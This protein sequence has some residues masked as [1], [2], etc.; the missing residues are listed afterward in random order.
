MRDDN[1]T[2]ASGIDRLCDAVAAI[3]QDLD[4]MRTVADPLRSHP[5]TPLEVQA[6]LEQLHLDSV[7]SA[8]RVA[9]LAATADGSSEVGDIDPAVE[10]EVERAATQQ[11]RRT[12]TAARLAVGVVEPMADPPFGV[13]GRSER[14]LAAHP[15]GS[16]SDCTVELTDRDALSTWVA[17]TIAHARAHAPA[18]AVLRV[19]H[20]DDRWVRVVLRPGEATRL[21]SVG[22][23]ALAPAERLTESHEV[24][25][26]RLG[27]APPA[28]G[29]PHWWQDL[30][31]ADV[32]TAARTVAD[33]LLWVHGAPGPAGVEGRIEPHVVVDEDHPAIER[34][35]A[36]DDGD[37]GLQVPPELLLA[38][39]PTVEAL[40]RAL[41][42]RVRSWLRLLG[43]EQ[44]AVSVFGGGGRAV[45]GIGGDDRQLRV[46]IRIDDDLDAGRLALLGYTPDADGEVATCTWPLD[47][48]DAACWHAVTA[49]AA[50]HGLR[51]DREVSTLTNLVAADPTP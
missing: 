5:A 41:A 18:I 40:G 20:T 46:V 22:D 50:V 25:L 19:G 33:T 42:E 30:P 27:Y 29:A 14:I 23:A 34:L 28:D 8:D 39:A 24:L 51:C 48:V 17:G 11:H 32:A 7:A 2:H 21:E 1:G 12:L 9:E 4:G 43:P 45:A 13:R 16:G 38:D 36:A 3:A 10:A 49:L 47:E 37:G 44:I 15:A 6:L 35:L 31:G 26:R